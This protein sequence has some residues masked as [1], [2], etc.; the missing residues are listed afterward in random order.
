ME[1]KESFAEEEFYHLYNRGN[2]KRDIFLN[3][4][5]RDRFIHLLYLCNSSKAVVL[6]EISENNFFSCDRGESL[7]DIG[8]YCLMPNHFHLLVRAKDNYGVSLFMKKLQ[9]AYSMY[10]NKKNER[11]GKLF[12]GVFRSKYVDNDRYL[13]YL[14][15]YIHLN[16]IKK[17]EPKWK[18]E[19][20]RNI[21][22]AKKFL[23]DFKYSSYIDY[24]LKERARPESAVIKTESFPEY[25]SAPKEFEEFIE[26]W[27]FYKAD[28]LEDS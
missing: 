5:D 9:T 7:V 15:S 19:G 11:T 16:P 22:R 14:Y 27:L 24:F 21:N 4:Q 2:D 20:I 13:E 17:I 28:N 23:N 10:F 3:D 6:K 26:E 8:A 12:E 1:R 25:F 18:E